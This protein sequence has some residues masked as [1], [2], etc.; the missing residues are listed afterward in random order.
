MSPMMNIYL[1]NDL[2]SGEGRIHLSIHDTHI[3]LPIHPDKSSAAIHIRI[4]PII[5]WVYI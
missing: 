3:T 1:Q 2:G 4:H 5:A